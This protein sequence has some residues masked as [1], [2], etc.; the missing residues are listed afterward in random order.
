MNFI[1]EAKAPQ[2]KS[3]TLKKL[4]G[5]GTY[6]SVYLGEKDGSEIALKLL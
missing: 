6:C 3:Y 4:I 5:K 1:E 2:T